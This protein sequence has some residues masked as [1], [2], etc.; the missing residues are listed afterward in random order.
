MTCCFCGKEL[1]KRIDAHNPEPLNSNEGTVCCL[2][3]NNELVGPVRKILW[4]PWVTKE[5]EAEFLRRF[6]IMSLDELYGLLK[7]NT[8]DNPD[9]YEKFRAKVFSKNVYWVS[10]P[11][12]KGEHLFTFDGQRIFNLFRDY[13]YELTFREQY[14]FNKENPYWAKFFWTRNLPGARLLY[15]LNCKIL[16][17][18]I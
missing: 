14:L 12:H 5:D 6:K 8:V 4:R 13:P 1:E 7:E 18:I 17:N 15:K 9:D 16:K 11:Q 3:C 10:N 2:R